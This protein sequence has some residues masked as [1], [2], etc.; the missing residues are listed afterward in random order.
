MLRNPITLPHAL[1]YII[2]QG[3]NL[4]EPYEREHDS[5][6]VVN[7]E[8]KKKYEFADGGAR[9]DGKVAQLFESPPS[10]VAARRKSLLVFCVVCGEQL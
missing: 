2:E 9:V 7:G 10:S 8:A 6:F 3:K 4:Q 5:D 1:S